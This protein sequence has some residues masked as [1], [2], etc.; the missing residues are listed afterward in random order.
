MAKTYLPDIVGAVKD[1]ADAI[2][3]DEKRRDHER[4]VA[5]GSSLMSLANLAVVVYLFEQTFSGFPFD[6]Q[7]AVV[8]LVT[9]VA[10][11]A[12]AQYITKGGEH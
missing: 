10:F 6:T 2:R 12:L 1:V 8:G 11:Y 7:A 9:W 3:D 5:F 4:R